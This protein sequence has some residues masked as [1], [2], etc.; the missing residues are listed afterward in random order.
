MQNRT[1]FATFFNHKS[2]KKNLFTQIISI[3][4]PNVN[5]PHPAGMETGYRQEKIEPARHFFFVV[6]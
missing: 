5:L 1:D 2:T 4:I 3:V 6:Y